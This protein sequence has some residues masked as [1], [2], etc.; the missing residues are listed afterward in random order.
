MS[1][2]K[3]GDDRLLW[4]AGQ[5]GKAIQRSEQ[6]TSRMLRLGHIPAT[7]VGDRWVTSASRLRHFLGQ[8]GDHG[9]DRV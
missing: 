7:R 2:L 6:A 1:E 3:S 5:I 4:G 9:G 8:G